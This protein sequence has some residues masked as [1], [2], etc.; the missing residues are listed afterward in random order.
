M[1]IF[2]VKA[3]SQPRAQVRWKRSVRL[4]QVC[5]FGAGVSSTMPRP[6]INFRASFPHSGPP[7]ARR[8]L[9]LGFSSLKISSSAAAMEAA[10]TFS[11]GRAIA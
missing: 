4:N 6:S 3:I 10:L 1:C 2:S 11:N 9:I 5:V 7:S 8:V